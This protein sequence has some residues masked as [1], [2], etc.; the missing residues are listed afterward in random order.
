MIDYLHNTFTIIDYLHNT[1]TMIDYLHNTFTI[2]LGGEVKEPE[3]FDT[4]SDESEKEKENDTNNTDKTDIRP[5]YVDHLRE[6][7]IYHGTLQIMPKR[8]TS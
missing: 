4:S 5:V 2:I 3:D 8:S 7:A 6:M 1:F